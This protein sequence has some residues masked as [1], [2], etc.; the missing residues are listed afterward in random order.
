[1]LYMCLKQNLKVGIIKHHYTVTTGDDIA[2]CPSV[3]SAALS[4]ENTVV[5]VSVVLVFLDIEFSGADDLLPTSTLA[6]I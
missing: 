4:S 5:R 1:M 2:S 6:E 3:T